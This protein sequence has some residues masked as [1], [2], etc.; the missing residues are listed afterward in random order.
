[1]QWPAQEKAHFLFLLTYTSA[2]VFDGNVLDEIAPL[3]QHKIIVGDKAYQKAMAS[4]RTENSVTFYTPVKK[5][6]GQ[7]FLDSAENYFQ[8]LFLLFD[9]Y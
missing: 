3:F 1:M 5:K 8:P 4:I 2:N 6:K 9:T 7:K